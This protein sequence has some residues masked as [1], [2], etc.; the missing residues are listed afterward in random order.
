MRLQGYYFVKRTDE[1][2]WE[3][4]QWIADDDDSAEDGFFW[5]TGLPVEFQDKDFTEVGSRVKMPD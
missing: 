1:D 2:G 3:I 4:A 5:M